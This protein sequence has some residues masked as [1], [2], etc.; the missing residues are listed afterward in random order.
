MGFPPRMESRGQAANT[1]ISSCSEGSFT[2][3]WLNAN[4]EI[5]GLGWGGVAPLLHLCAGGRAPEL[6]CRDW[7]HLLTPAI[8]TPDCGDSSPRWE[9]FL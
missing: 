7:Q 3:S 4:L 1:Q 6:S 2:S 9:S 8:R 5:Q